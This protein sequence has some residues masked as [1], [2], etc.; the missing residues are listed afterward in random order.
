MALQ[1]SPEAHGRNP[2]VD[3][4]PGYDL[5]RPRKFNAAVGG[6]HNSPGGTTSHGPVPPQ[7]TP[8]FD[9]RRREEQRGGGIDIHAR[10]QRTGWQVTPTRVGGQRSQYLVRSKKDFVRGPAHEGMGEKQE[11]TQR[12]ACL[13]EVCDN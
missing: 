12:R 10:E 1:E 9:D 3:V 5:Q 11:K 4:L 8:A 13:G 2:E 6:R 7:N